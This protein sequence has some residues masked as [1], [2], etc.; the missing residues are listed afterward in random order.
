MCRPKWKLNT[1]WLNKEV[2][3]FYESIFVSPYLQL[4]DAKE[5]KLYNVLVS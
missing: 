2:Y 4:Y 5:D 1:K 3:P